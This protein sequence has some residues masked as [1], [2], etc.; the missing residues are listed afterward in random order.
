MIP[1]CRILIGEVREQLDGLPDQ[2]VHAIVTSPPYWGLRDYGTAPVAWPAGEYAPIAGV[3]PVQY[4]AWSGELGL[5]P[6]PLMFVGHIVEVFRRAHRVLRDDGTLWVNF[7]DCYVDG[8][9]G[10]DTKSTLEGGRHNQ[11]ES[12]KATHR[13]QFKGLPPKNLLYQP[14]RV[15]LAL[16][17]DGWILRKDI[18]WCLSGGA[19]VYART[20]NGEGPAMVKDLVR[21]NPAT[22]RL[23]NGEKWT[24]VLGWSRSTGEGERLELVLRSGERIGCTGG[25]QWP[26]QRGNVMA[27]ELQVGDVIKTC[28]LPEPEDC[29]RPDF[30]TDD[31]LW[32]IG[33]YLAEGSRSGNKHTR[34]LSLCADERHWVPRLAAVAKHYGGSIGST[35][36]G[37]SLAVRVYGAVLHALID[38]YVGGLV[39]SDK[40]LNAVAWNLPNADL[41]RIAWGY[42]DGDGHAELLSGRWRLGFCRNYALE[43]DIRTLAARVGATITLKPAVAKYQNGNAPSFRGEW[44]WGR[45]GHHNEK[46]RGEVMAIRRSRARK[47][48]DIGVEDDPHLF[49]LASGV[50]THNSKANPMPESC[51]DRPTT[52]HEYVYLFSKSKRYYYDQEAVKEPVSGTANARSAAASQFPGELFRD[53]NRRRGRVPGL[54]P[55]A[56][57]APTGWDTSVGE[58]GHGKI[59]K[60]GREGANSR[61]LVDRVPRERKGDRTKPKQNPSYAAAM[62]SLVTSRNCRD[63]WTMATEPYPEAHYAT[64]PMELVR[65]PIL[66]GCPKGGTVLDPFGGSGTTGACALKYGRSAILIDLNP[67]NERLMRDRLAPHEGQGVLPV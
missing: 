64:F 9:R 50:L 44:R 46:D 40:H 38:E 57:A 53:D 12:R 39:A 65:R 13:T 19:W 30:I 8:G 16:Q 56:M 28:G 45:S 58:G 35:I 25:H 49:A 42:L 29:R 17:A 1:T 47:F 37:G 34:Q 33:L 24:R 15:A 59:Y 23:W 43:R 36:K 6:D 22:V 41:Q 63:V 10:S 7:G 20:Q 48:W 54:N 60:L 21:L 2:C 4:P 14:A 18:I 5:E 11:A 66:A 52:A 51:R 3:P 61:M 27:R 62:V 55:K 31:A 32:L 26:T 67:A